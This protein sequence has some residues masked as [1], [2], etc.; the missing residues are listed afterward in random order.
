MSESGAKSDIWN[1]RYCDASNLF[2]ILTCPFIVEIEA[3]IVC[4][5]DTTL[6]PPSSTLS[7]KILVLDLCG[8]VL[9]NFNLQYQI[10]TGKLV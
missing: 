2:D 4:K 6:V 8:E 9:F 5:K 7:I 3:S 10:V 1:N